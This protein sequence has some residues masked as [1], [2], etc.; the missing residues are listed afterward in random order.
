[1]FFFTPFLLPSFFSAISCDLTRQ[2]LDRVKYTVGIMTTWMSAPLLT[3]NIM[4]GQI[5]VQHLLAIVSLVS[6][7]P[8]DT[9]ARILRMGI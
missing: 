3:T 4:A 9:F 7:S 1:M 2:L 8:L 5:R 6:G